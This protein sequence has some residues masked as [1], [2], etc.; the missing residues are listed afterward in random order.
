MAYVVLNSI[1]ILTPPHLP[2]L[3]PGI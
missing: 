3:S 1:L 2:G